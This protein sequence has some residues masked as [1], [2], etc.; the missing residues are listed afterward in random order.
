[1]AGLTGH[2]NISM[3]L[4]EMVMKLEW[5]VK[6][7]TRMAAD[8]AAI[9]G[10][11]AA[12]WVIDNTPSDL[13]H[14]YKGD[15]NWTRNMRDSLDHKVTP[16]GDKIEVRAGWLVNQEGYFLTQEHGGLFN[17]TTITPMNALVAAHDAMIDTLRV[18]GIKT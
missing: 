4:E 9:A 6:T 5:D 18:W 1:M 17:G 2:H 12:E 15:R 10:Q 7:R 13:S 16:S 3:G 14:K 11:H 8:A